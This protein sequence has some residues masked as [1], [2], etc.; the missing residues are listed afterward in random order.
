MHRYSAFIITLLPFLVFQ[1]LL[2]S[3]FQTQIIDSNSSLPIVV[4]HILF[5]EVFSMYCNLLSSMIRKLDYYQMNK[6]GIIIQCYF[7]VTLNP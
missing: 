2:F 1:S 5:M 3:F 4:Y 6:N 7:D